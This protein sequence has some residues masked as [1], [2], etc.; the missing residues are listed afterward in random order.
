M[1]LILLGGNSLQNKTWIKEVEMVFKPDFDSTRI[2]YYDHWQTGEKVIG[3][4]KE[5]EKMVS[6]LA[7]Q[8]D[9]VIFA[10]S[11]GTFLTLKAVH[12]K[13][14]NPKKCIFVGT[15]VLWSRAHNFGADEWLEGYSIPTLFVQKTLDPVMHFADLKTLLEQLAVKNYRLVEIPGES[16]DYESIDQLKG[17]TLKFL[18]G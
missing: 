4:D 7:G 2:Q 12:R 8:K 6:S 13:L 3:F 5:L 11:I 14:I 18:S 17:L 15:P 16:H 1:N 10:K 9:Y